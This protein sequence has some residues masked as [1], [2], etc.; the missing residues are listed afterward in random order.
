M[1]DL[2]AALI[3]ANLIWENKDDNKRNF[4]KLIEKFVSDEND[5]I[6]L[7]EMFTTGF[8]MTPQLLAEKME[9]ET[10]DWMF[11]MATKKDA[12]VTGSIIIEEN[13]DYF[14]RLIWMRPDGQYQFYDKHHLFTLAGEDKI[15]TS[16]KMLL[17][18]EYKG[19]KISPF[20]CYDLRFPVW[21]RNTTDYDIILLVANWPQKRIDQWEHM[22]YSRAIENQ[23]YLLAVNRIGE[24]NNGLA[25]NGCSMAISPLGR[26]LSKASEIEAVLEVTLSAEKLISAR[27]QMQFLRDRDEFEVKI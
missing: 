18:I 22:L 12:V 9:S 17:M 11:K 24:D 2:K 6:V 16:G 21:L 8:T 1:Q 26:L 27:E 13:K 4:T 19:W 5:I 25:H 20:I 7:P 14:N 23:S 10:M 15:Y 3:Q